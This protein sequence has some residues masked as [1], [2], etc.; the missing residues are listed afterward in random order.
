MESKFIQPI[1]PKPTLAWKPKRVGIIQPSVF[2]NA[3]PISVEEF[4]PKNIEP[5]RWYPGGN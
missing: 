4:I 3:V 1:V 2:V 5:T